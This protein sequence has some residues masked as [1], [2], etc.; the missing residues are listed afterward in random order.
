MNFNAKCHKG[1]HLA[2][3]QVTFF[4]HKTAIFDGK[5]LFFLLHFQ[6]DDLLISDKHIYN[7]KAEAAAKKIGVDYSVFVLIITEKCLWMRRWSGKTVS[8]EQ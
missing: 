8:K 7:K 5:L 3:K 1:V 4:R 6:I 2:L